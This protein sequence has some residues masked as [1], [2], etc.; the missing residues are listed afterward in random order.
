MSDKEDEFQDD[1]IDPN[2]T[3]MMEGSTALAIV[4]HLL[5]LVLAFVGPQ[6]AKGL[7]DEMVVKEAN[8]A[9]DGAEALKFRN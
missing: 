9:A 5:Q 7:I 3:L 8:A 4:E 2:E 6:K 1:D